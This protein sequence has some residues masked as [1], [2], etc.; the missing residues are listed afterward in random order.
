MIKKI[1]SPTTRSR[2]RWRKRQRVCKSENISFRSSPP[3]T[4]LLSLH[5]LQ[6]QVEQ[7][8]MNSGWGEGKKKK[9]P[10]SHD[11]CRFDGNYYGCFQRRDSCLT[12]LL[13]SSLKRRTRSICRFSGSSTSISLYPMTFRLHAKARGTATSRLRDLA[14]KST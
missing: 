13:T 12:L 6:Q 9:G 11:S 3:L 7:L 2:P 1:I 14:K 10:D 8:F 4:Q 5:R